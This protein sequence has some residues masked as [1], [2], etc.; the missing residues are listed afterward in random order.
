MPL[1]TL[2]SLA[3]HQKRQVLGY[4]AFAIAALVTLAFW[5]FELRLAIASHDEREQEVLSTHQ[6]RLLETRAE[7]FR[8]LFHEIYQ[9]G[10]TISLLPSIRGAH[11]PNRSSEDEDVVAQGRLS[12]DADRTLQQV[13]A[14]LASNV[15]VS[16]VYFVMDGFDPAR[17]QVPFFMYD[18][19]VAKPGA[20]RS[21]I[22][23][24]DTPAEDE[25]EEYQTIRRQLEWFRENAPQFAYASDLNAIP[26]H[27][28]PPVRTC[29]NTQYTSLASGAV[30]DAQGIVISIPVY[31][32][33]TGN[34]KGQVSIILRLNVLEALLLE[35]PFLPVTDEDRGRMSAAGWKMPSPAPFVLVDKTRSI[36]VIDRRNRVLGAGLVAALANPSTGGRWASLPVNLPGNGPWELHHHLTDAEIDRLVGSIRYSKQLSIVGRAALL[37]VLASALAAGAWLV[38]SSRREL[39]RIAHV[40][41]LTGL[42]N[43]RL[44]FDRLENGIARAQRNGTRLGLFFLDLADLNAVNDRYGHQGG[45]LVLVE[46]SRRLQQSLRSTDSIARGANAPDSAGESRPQAPAR[47]LLSR[48]GG[49][50]FTV[51]CEDLQAQD[52]LIVV[53]ERIIACLGERFTLRSESVEIGVNVGAALYPDDAAD[54]E[55]LLMS[56]D[57]AMHECKAIGAPYVL[58]NEGMRKRAERQHL[59]V[60]E[61]VN[62][63]QR[64]QFELFYQPKAVIAD[65][66]VAALEALIRW[67]HPALGMVPPLD[68][69]PICERSGSIIEIGQWIIE[70]A[71]RDLQRLTDAG[72][73]RIK[74]SVNVS[75]RQLK[76]AGFVDFLARTLR[77]FG[78][79]PG[80]LILEVTESMVMEDLA[81]GR[82]S[83]QQ[84][85]ELGVSLALDDFGAGYSSMTYLQQLPLDSL[86]IDK[87]LVDGMTDDRSIHVVRTVIRL[88]QGLSL[89][90][91]AEGVETVEQR[92]L[93]GRL[94]CDM[95]QG[96]LLSR[97]APLPAIL[98]WIAQRQRDA[99]ISVAD[100]AAGQCQ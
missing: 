98:D 12:V 84:L 15:R 86:K 2:K 3:S 43:R 55:R 99:E 36:E 83:L 28:S 22:P 88:A 78:T 68:F 21:P 51:L 13:Y 76:H 4:L 97:P 1:S 62:A 79:D 50:E 100:C 65:G 57:S 35:V 92:D 89:K 63:L 7:A 33:D 41:Q 58:F 82:Q 67:R 61:L 18:D 11:G 5:A 42:P 10:R 19:L 14:N 6:N 25:T 37:L 16:E 77:E 96:Y 34:F 39:V 95:I 38:R 20:T 52:D 23:G 66:S 49:D 31:D 70:Q 56:A 27:I 29:D 90:T 71:C 91:I 8:D 26:S 93:L 80:R 47:F 54:A 53:A 59:M 40:D 74:L 72:H 73:T 44:F 69:I 17:G 32:A 9:T 87:S 30:R 46:V 64:Q 45:D 24:S 81:N 85:K 60:L 94:G 75:V 48:L